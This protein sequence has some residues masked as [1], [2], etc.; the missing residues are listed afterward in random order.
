MCADLEKFHYNTMIAALMELSNYLGRVREER[1]ASREAFNEAVEALMLLMAPS[2]PHI[3]EELWERTG[4][5]YSIHDQRLP[6]WDE[7]LAAE[8]EVTL[9]V[10]V[11]GKLRDKLT[12]AVTITEDE[13]KELALGREK[14][15]SYI[16]GKRINKVI[17]V[18]GRLVN[19]VTS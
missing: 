5:D 14:I 10:Q 15:K 12:V 13:A 9:V 1:T 17:Y 18:P 4:H 2:T 19:I 6:E 7:A 16:E 11:N 3:A 8:E